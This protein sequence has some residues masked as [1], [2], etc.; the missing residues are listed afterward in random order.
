LDYLRA[1][2]LPPNKRVEE[3]IG[4]LRVKQLPDGSWP[5]DVRYAA[6][7]PV[8]LGELPGEPSRW[9]TLRA[10]RVLRWFAG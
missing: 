4:L 8:D 10:M 7:M 6:K 9:I 5:L 3:P 2:G 1:A